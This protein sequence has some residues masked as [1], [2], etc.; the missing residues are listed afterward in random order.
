[1]NFKIFLCKKMFSLK[2]VWSKNLFRS[3]DE[4]KLEESQYM[5]W[6]KKRIQRGKRAPIYIE[7][8]SLISTGGYLFSSAM[9]NSSRPLFKPT[10]TPFSYCVTFLIGRLH[11]WPHQ[12]GKNRIERLTTTSPHLLYSFKSCFLRFI[13]FFFKINKWQFY[14]R[15]M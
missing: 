7:T 4:I 8:I 6:V 11:Q 3:G 12:A 5:E 10:R 1:M 9:S 15:S 2:N 13:I 14:F